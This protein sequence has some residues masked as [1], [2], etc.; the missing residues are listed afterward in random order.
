MR[1]LISVLAILVGTFGVVGFAGVAPAAAA[2]CSVHVE[3]PGV[4]PSGGS[5]SPLI[6][7]RAGF[8][9]CSD[10]SAVRWKWSF[11]SATQGTGFYDG[12]A[13][14]YVQGSTNDNPYDATVFESKADF[15]LNIASETSGPCHGSYSA[16]GNCDR[17][18]L[19]CA[20]WYGAPNRQLEAILGWQIKNRTT[21]T[22]GTV[23][24][25]AGAFSSPLSVSIPPSL[26]NS[27]Y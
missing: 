2:N 3:Q 16:S 14:A 18:I 9:A 10:V 8:Y 23:H 13:G 22:W 19:N 25:N 1:K 24:A 21:G 5:G 6:A 27:G 17:Y 4:Y 7:A 20:Y 11:P 15:T 26:C 12:A